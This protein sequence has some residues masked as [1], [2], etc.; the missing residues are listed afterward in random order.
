MTQAAPFSVSAWLAALGA[1]FAPYAPFFEANDVKAGVL[2]LLTS[3]DLREMGVTSIGHRRRILAAAAAMNEA[4]TLSVVDPLLAPERRIITVMFCDIV[5]STA[6]AAASGDEDFIDFISTVRSGIEATLIPFGGSV[7][8]FLGDGIMACFGYPMASEH[9]AERAVAAGLAVFE[10]ISHICLPGSDQPVML[11]I[12]IATGVTVIGATPD[13]RDVSAI[14]QTPNLA[15]RLQAFAAPGCLVI[16][17]QTHDLIG[18]MFTCEDLGT[19]PLKGITDAGRVWRVVA[20]APFVT[21]F[22]ALRQSSAREGAFVG[23]KIEMTRLTEVLHSGGTL[24]ITGD[25]GIGKSRLLHEATFSAGFSEPVYLQCSPYHSGLALHPFRYFLVQRCGVGQESDPAKLHDAVHGLLAT[26]PITTPDAVAS[27]V[28]FIDLAAEAPS[29]SRRSAADLRAETLTILA[30]LVLEM[31]RK[32]GAIA[33]EDAHWLDPSSLQ[34]LADLIPVLH[35]AGV[36]IIITARPNGLPALLDIMPVLAL[37]RLPLDE[38]ARLVHY[39]AAGERLSDD[40]VQLIAQRSD[41]VPI[42][43]EELVR[44]YLD[45]AR[46]TGPDDPLA[47]VPLSLAE[48]ILA[49]LDR[50]VQGRRIASLAA[51]IGREFPVMVLIS[52]SDLPA[53]VVYAG[54]SELLKAGILEPG[55]SQFGVAIRFCHNLVR[56]AAYELLLMRQRTALH[57]HIAAVLEHDFPEVAR[58]LPHILANQRALAGEY[59]AASLGWE[60]AGQIA[61]IRSAYAEAAAFYRKALECTDR[62]PPAHAR[63]SREMDLR[64]LRIGALICSQ[65]YQS[66]GVVEE[67]DRIMTLAQTLGDPDAQI[68]AMQSRWVMLGS[69]NETRAALEFALQALTA[70]RNGIGRHRLLAMRMCATSFLFAG[71]LIDA[72]RNYRSFLELFD[73]DLHGYDMKRGH[74][75]HRVMI[76]IGLAETL[77]LKGETAEAEHWRQSSIAEAERSGRLHDRC[78]ALV[79]AGVLHP[80]LARRFDEAHRNLMRLDALLRNQD[81]P[82]W[83]GY[84]MLFNGYLRCVG[85]DPA[86]AF[87]LGK[88]GYETLQ[89]A[90]VFGSWWHLIF[91]A[92][93]LDAQKWGDAEGALSEAGR[94]AEKGDQRF[95]AER[96]RLNARLLTERDSDDLAAEDLCRRALQVAI[97][98]QAVPLRSPV[99]GSKVWGNGSAIAPLSD[100]PV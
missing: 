8:Q 95:E 25:P 61:D 32:A 93:A 50:L 21:R 74:S 64:L 68:N 12:G 11:R 7:M 18:R 87:D 38:I 5:G 27:L 90:R 29:S 13:T 39:V 67:N 66:S 4:T 75:D 78:H 54:I 17:Q 57:A 86:S 85:G 63:D 83:Q 41:G 46:R 100:L 72:E 2:L 98:Q 34:L 77:L 24:L 23:R 53:N 9:D 91:A 35:Q 40:A 44:G 36:P 62:L 97:K 51:A 42:Y 15:A 16:S 33:I 96:L 45:S 47:Q 20:P 26:L 19:P 6:L 81:M 60:R 59:D 73:P 69:A 76:E 80:L 56:E 92:T 52:V 14:G 30:Q 1:E 55:H 71:N 65:G 49:R 28:A 99:L 79:Y 58:A 31:A 3:D 94:I 82:N 88:A 70:T 10:A 89:A 48:S 37:D 22:A 84:I 43:A